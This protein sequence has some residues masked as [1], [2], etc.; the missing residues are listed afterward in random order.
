MFSARSS[1][2]LLG[3]ASV[4]WAEEIRLDGWTAVVDPATLAVRMRVGGEELVVAAGAARLADLGLTAKLSAE[5]KRLRVRVE[6]ARE[7][8][9]EWPRT[10]M[11]ARISALIW[12]EGEGLYLP[13]TD[14]AW[15]RRESR[16]CYTA[17]GGLSMPWWAFAAGARAVAYRVLTD[18]RTEICLADGGGRLEA[19]AKH[20]FLDRDS[21]PA[22]EVEIWPSGASPIDP[23]LDYRS[24]TSPASLRQKMSANPLVERLLGAVHMYVWGDGRSVEFLADLKRLGI[25]RAWIGYD[26]NEAG[27]FVAGPAYVQ[28]AKAAGFLVGPYDTYANAQDSVR[29]DDAVSRWPGDLYPAGCVVKA[30]GGRKEGFANRGCELSSEALERLGRRPLALRLDQQL[31]HGAN[32]YFLD[33]D[34][35]GELHDDYAREHPMTQWRDRENRLRRLRDARARGVVLGSEEGAG[36]SV[37]A[38]DFAHGALSVHNAALWSMKKVFGGWWPPERPRIFFQ[39]VDPGTEFAAAKYDPAVRV[40]LYEAAFHDAVVATDRWDVPLGKFPVLRKRRVLLEALYG[41]PSIWAMDRRVLRE[42]GEWLKRW[43]AFFEPL[44]R[45]VGTL[46][47]TS[48]EWLSA[49]RLVQ[50]TRFGDRVAVTADF[51]R[52]CVRVEGL[53]GGPLE[54]CPD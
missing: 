16:R 23:A 1:A 22:Y 2:L 17:H 35:F 28:A 48:F 51:S 19:L 5:G 54:Y 31:R 11:D 46:P 50:R 41:V 18:I 43:Y 20:T 13:F 53:D 38:I 44:H 14:A 42:A 33:V 45:G 32:S 49:D 52:G 25:R 12:P 27:K 3:V 9:F 8:T 30:D 29:A 15:R 4:V 21:R 47:L 24:F 10:G 6:S 36:W 7:Q 39:P 26:Q 37:P 40:P 34:A